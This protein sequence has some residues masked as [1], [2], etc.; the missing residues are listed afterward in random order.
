MLHK[1]YED[2]SYPQVLAT[3]AMNF[4]Y[5]RGNIVKESWF[6]ALAT[7][8]SIDFSTGQVCLPAFN[9]EGSEVGYADQSFDPSEYSTDSIAPIYKDFDSVKT[10][11]LVVQ[12]ADIYMELFEHKDTWTALP[13]P[14]FFQECISNIQITITNE[15][16]KKQ[17]IASTGIG[18]VLRCF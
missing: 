2:G 15:V 12:L 13:S 5:Y 1:Q 16:Y 9:W 8:M 3:P 17:C 11:P 14:K 10:E 7:E 6:K 18:E 4:D